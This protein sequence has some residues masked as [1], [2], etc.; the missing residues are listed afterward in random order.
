MP[1]T[2]DYRALED[3]IVELFNN[4]DKPIVWKGKYFNVTASCKPR[5]QRGGGECKTDVY[6]LLNNTEEGTSDEIKISVKK[7]DAEFLANKLTASVA[8]DLLGSNWSN[9]LIDSI[10]PIRNKFMPPTE[11]VY[12]KTVKG[13]T[14]AYF[15]LGWKLEVTDKHRALS[16]KLNLSNNEII[17]IIFKG[18]NQPVEKKNALVFEGTA[19]ANSGIA[20]YLLKGSQDKY[21]DAQ[22][23]IDDLIYLDTYDAGDIYLAFT[24]NNYR[25]TAN[26]ADGPRALVVA[27]RWTV[28]NNRLSPEFIFN[29][30]LIFQGERDM[31]PSIKLCLVELGIKSIADIDIGEIKPS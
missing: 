17:K 26:K 24:A 28:E 22:S 30:P 16:A 3:Y 4:I 20:E 6:V 10:R 31:M 7:D 2:M 8:E 27:V 1:V 14:D 13:D 5:P 25:I 15:T 11:L 29:E 12:L 23:V 9:I 21:P 18:E 19:Q